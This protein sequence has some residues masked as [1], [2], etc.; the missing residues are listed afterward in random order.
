MVFTSQFILFPQCTD[1]S[2]H[3]YTNGTQIE[4][5]KINVI[6]VRDSLLFFRIISNIEN[7]AIIKLCKRVTVIVDASCSTSLYTVAHV[8]ERENIHVTMRARNR[9]KIFCSIA[10]PEYLDVSEQQVKNTYS[11]HNIER[12]RRI[13][14]QRILF[15]NSFMLTLDGT[16][17]LY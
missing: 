1:R 9:R 6:F 5:R 12:K 11:E 4:K 7:T 8:V 15:S 10:C 16:T 17:S 14:T 13:P 3:T 2:T